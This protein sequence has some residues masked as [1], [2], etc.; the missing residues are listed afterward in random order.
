MIICLNKE[1][2][3]GEEGKEEEEKGEGEKEREEERKRENKLI[4]SL[5]SYLGG[6]G[7]CYILEQN[8]SQINRHIYV[9]MNVSCHTHTHTNNLVDSTLSGGITDKELCKS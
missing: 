9:H 6:Q 8:V 5:S 7:H 3:R 4:L 1:K 2:R